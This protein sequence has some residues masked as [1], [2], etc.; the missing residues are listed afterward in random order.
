VE[1]TADILEQLDWLQTL[2]NY[3]NTFN[4]ERY[5]K[6]VMDYNITNVT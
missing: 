4:A 1:H 6:K 2:N 5:F 3:G